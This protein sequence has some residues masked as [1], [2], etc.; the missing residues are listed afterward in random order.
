MEQASSKDVDINDLSYCRS[1]NNVL[2][3]VSVRC[4]RDARAVGAAGNRTKPAG[5]P[6]A[7]MPVI[8]TL[9]A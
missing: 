7:S 5:K 4:L 3:A 1:R 6:A 2:N 8:D 9:N